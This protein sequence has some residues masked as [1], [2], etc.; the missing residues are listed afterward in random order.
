MH[1]TASDGVYPPHKVVQF[2]LEF[3]LDAIAITDH[4]TTDGIQPARE[5]AI[6]K[7]IEVIAGVELGCEN[8]VRDVHILGY[9]IDI[10]N[11]ELQ[12][13]FQEM[14]HVRETRA[15]SMIQK[16]GEMGVRISLE[17]VKE[18]AG[19]APIVRPHIAK[20]MIEAHA[21]PDMQTAFEKY[22]GNDAPAYA[23]RMRLLP[24]RAIE[25]I[26][27]AGGVAILAHAGR[28]A[29]PL[30]VAN[31]MVDYGIDGIEVFYPTHEPEFRE[32]LLK[33]ANERGLLVTGGSDF[34]RPNGD[35]SLPLGSEDVPLEIIEK[36]RDKSRQFVAKGK[37]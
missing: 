15:E 2:A 8:D 22:I 5:A 26:H 12:K 3:G 21:V 14:R 25:I 23:P 13:A 7:P 30:E 34:H 10:E 24:E 11:A 9:Y 28:Y 35:G 20:A 29:S 36:L 37:S 27:N 17:R 33:I 6:D 18:I 1:T 31:E 32:A 16:M 4:D 19:K